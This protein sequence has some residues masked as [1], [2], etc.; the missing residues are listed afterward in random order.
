M[1][2]PVANSI[3][4]VFFLRSTKSGFELTPHKEGLW[5]WSIFLDSFNWHRIF[6]SLEIIEYLTTKETVNLIILFHVGFWKLSYDLSLKTRLQVVF[7]SWVCLYFPRKKIIPANF[8]K[9]PA[10]WLSPC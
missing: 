8:I 3:A 4:V 2:T 9:W 7:S 10:V 1:Y 6:D 5:F